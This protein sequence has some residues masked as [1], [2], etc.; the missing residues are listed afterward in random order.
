MLVTT[1]GT[2]THRNLY[3]TPMSCEGKS[4]VTGMGF[5]KRYSGP[6]AARNEKNYES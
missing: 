6:D 5:R 1:E 2:E 4:G 3:S